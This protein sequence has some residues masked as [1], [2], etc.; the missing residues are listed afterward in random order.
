MI[1]GANSTYTKIQRVKLK[2]PSN[3]GSRWEGIKH[4]ELVAGLQKQCRSRR[5]K[6]TDSQYHLS[7]DKFDICGAFALLIPRVRKL[8][9]VRYE[10]GFVHSN[11]RRKALK[12]VVGGSVTVCSNG[13]V[14]GE[15]V[16]HHRHEKCLDWE[17]KLPVAFDAFKQRVVEMQQ[18][19]ETLKKDEISKEHIEHTLMETGR[20]KIL[21]W[22]RI[23]T[24]DV[25][26]NDPQHHA[27]HGED[28][29]W[30]LLNA[31]TQVVKRQNPE[32]QMDKIREFTELLWEV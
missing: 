11:A 18:D 25:L 31:F 15:I 20:R 16:M 14:A 1:Y 27:M 24:V 17:E 26:M 29:S 2:R 7:R 19:M 32:H 5:W 9:G 30:S 8:R 23:G 13:L 21:P 6:I 3:A 10:M 22:S 4:G 12:I 28:T